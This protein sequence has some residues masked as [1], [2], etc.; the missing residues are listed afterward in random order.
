[1]ISPSGLKAV[2]VAKML[3]AELREKGAIKK[4]QPKDALNA[5]ITP[6]SIG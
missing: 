6:R 1:M 5:K 4:R 3:I 2:L